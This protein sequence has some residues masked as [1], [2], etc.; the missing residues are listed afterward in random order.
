MSA[1]KPKRA[2]MGRPT[3]LTPEVQETIRSAL[4]GGA[5][6]QTAVL[7]AGISPR[8][9]FIWMDRGTR[10]GT[11][12]FAD[13]V[14]NYVQKGKAQGEL[15]L[16]LLISAAARVHWQAAAWILERRW[17]QHWARNEQCGRQG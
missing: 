2:P 1:K 8:T 14:H 5:R 3:K 10:E 17:R 7:L 11:G 13:F 12:P 4:A 15:R 16:L 9:F 6:V